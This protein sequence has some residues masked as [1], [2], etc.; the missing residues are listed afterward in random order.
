MSK[1]NFFGAYKY[2]KKIFIRKYSL[3]KNNRLVQYLRGVW[4]LFG[5]SEN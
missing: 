3:C 1:I 4:E 5:Q 2:N